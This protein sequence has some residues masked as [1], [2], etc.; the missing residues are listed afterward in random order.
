[1]IE[2]I[3]KSKVLR[4]KHDK[5]KLIIHAPTFISI[6]WHHI[7]RTLKEFWRILPEWKWEK[8]E[9]VQHRSYQYSSLKWDSIRESK[10]FEIFRILFLDRGGIRTH[11]N[12]S[13][14]RSNLKS[15]GFK[16]IHQ[17]EEIVLKNLLMI[18]LAPQ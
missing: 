6:E 2:K 14:T 17:C 5:M 10:N 9:R 12:L 16:E 8:H 15:F 11:A 4:A 1:M 7:C 13:R 3:L 18:V